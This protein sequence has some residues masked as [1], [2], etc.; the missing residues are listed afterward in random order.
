MIE[1][2]INKKKQ[3]KYKIK[4]DKL[5]QLY[6]RCMVYEDK[7]SKLH[8]IWRRKKSEVIFLM[9]YFTQFISFINSKFRISKNAYLNFLFQT[10]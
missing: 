5:S 7:T 3:K 2:E 8:T 1:I 9:T 6:E 4:I 10:T